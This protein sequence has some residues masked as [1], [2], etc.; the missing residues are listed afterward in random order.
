[1]TAPRIAIVGGGMSGLAA[2][3]YLSRAGCEVELFE[4]N[5]SLGGCCATTTVDGYTFNDGAMFLAV[6][7]LLD[8]AFERLGL[9][10]GARLPLRRIEVPQASA[11]DSGASVVL[12]PGPTL[13]IEGEDGRARTA[14]AQDQL[15]RFLDR[16]RPLLRI[17]ADD[18]LTRP[19]SLTHVIASAWR[20]LPQLR[21]TLAQELERAFDDRDVRSALSAVALYTGLAPERTPIFQVFG[22][23]SMF[24]DGLQLPVQG[25]GAIAD[26]LA[27]ALREAGGRIHLATPVERILADR[28][29]ADGVQV[30]GEALVFDC[31]ISTVGGMNTFERLI[32]PA[33]VPASMK[34]RV[35]KAPL[36][37]R[38]LAVQLGL[39]NA[40][41]PAAFCVN[42][43]PAMDEQ[44][45]MHGTPRLGDAW[46]SYT[47]PTTVLPQLAPEG[48]SVV[49]MYVGVD[50]RQPLNAWDE[51]TT[52][53]A[54]DA[55][56]AR[57]ARHQTLDIA[58]LRTVTPREHEQR[59]HLY[60]GAL[61]GL[62]PAATPQQ[63]FP[64]RTPIDGLILAGQT[65]YP[66][67]GVAT[68]M[69]SGIF[70]ADEALRRR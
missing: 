27:Q 17:F 52:R 54:A 12:G 64:H 65:T 2:G 1:M 55:A 35:A 25:M 24:D 62:S 39:R 33:W 41:A 42:H 45:R 58:R 32:D 37:H 31:V 22:I 10:R 30:G 9:D 21:G 43:V 68:A 29:H 18:L 28:A 38:A 66:G 44:H 59:M 23:V 7:Q 6:P 53:A 51:S 46:L 57:L 34:R 8:H 40:I 15:A 11:L 49:E 5:E 60:G 20:Y 19:M 13:R 14:R 48:G 67:F 26:V 70:A 16:W 50:P 63:Q 4:A 3:V 56:I 69:L 61:Y 47:V 36:S